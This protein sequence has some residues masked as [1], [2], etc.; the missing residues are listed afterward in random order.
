[1][2]DS[3]DREAAGVLVVGRLGLEA[4]YWIPVPSV[5]PSI[6]LNSGCICRYSLGRDLF[7]F[8]TLQHLHKSQ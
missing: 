8:I 4:V 2:I 5:Q 6:S 7:V 3:R 1:M